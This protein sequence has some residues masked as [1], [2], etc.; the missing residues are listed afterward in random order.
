MDAVPTAVHIFDHLRERPSRRFPLLRQFQI[1]PLNVADLGDYN[2][3]LAAQ[4]SGPHQLAEDGPDTPLAAAIHVVGGGV[5]QVA[6]LKQRLLQGLVVLAGLIVD[7]VPAEA[8]FAGDEAGR[9][10]RRIARRS[11]TGSVRSRAGLSCA[12]GQKRSDD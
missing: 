9:S 1:L 6:A 10:E 2:D 5:D 12:T 8:Q 4:F 3:L 11:K 7:P